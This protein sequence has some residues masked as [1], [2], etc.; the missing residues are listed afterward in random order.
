MNLRNTCAIRSR[1]RVPGQALGLRSR[2]FKTSLTLGRSPLTNRQQY[3]PLRVLCKSVKKDQKK[4]VALEKFRAP[5]KVRLF[6]AAI[7][8]L[9]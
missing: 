1:E 5:T 6:W 2:S 9:S 8:A 7:Q 4:N 3:I